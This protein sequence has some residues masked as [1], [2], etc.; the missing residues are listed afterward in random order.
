MCNICGKPV[1]Y[2]CGCSTEPVYCADDVCLQKMDAK[3]VFY[4]YNHPEKASL[5]NCLGINSNIN[6]EV[7]LEAIDDKLCSL[8]SVGFNLLAIDTN[9][10]NTTIINS[11]S[12][13]YVKSDLILD[14]SST[15]PVS[16]TSAGLKVDCCNCTGVT[17][18]VAF[19]AG[20]VIKS[21]N[22]YTT[23]SASY[24]TSSDYIVGVEI[25]DLSTVSGDTINYIKYTNTL[26]GD[27]KIITSI[28]TTFN[29]IINTCGKNIENESKT[30]VAELS[31]SRN[32]YS[33]TICPLITSRVGY[34]ERINFPYRANFQMDDMPIISDPEAS[35][36]TDKGILFFADTKYYSPSTSNGGVIRMINLNDKKCISLSGSMT[37]GISATTV[38]NT[39]GDIVQYDYPSS[40]CIDKTEITNGYP[41]LYFTAFN[42]CICRM[43]R[44]RTTEC[45]ERAN[46]KT[47]I[48]AGQSGVVGDVVGAG[49]SALFR[50]LYGIKKWYSLNGKPAFLVADSVNSKIKFVYYNGGG[51]NSASNWRVAYFGINTLGGLS[52]NINVEDSPVYPGTKR[53]FN[54]G[55]GSITI[56]DFNFTNPT[57]TDLTTLAN[58]VSHTVISAAAVG[59]GDGLGTVARVYNPS[60]ISKMI[61]S[62]TT[63]YLFS[64]EDSSA[65]PLT[66]SLRAFVESGY[67][68]PA[69]YTFTT[70]IAINT[71]P[72]GSIG[73]FGSTARGSSFGFFKDLQG[74]Y[75]DI[76]TGGIRLF[77]FASNT[78]SSIICGASSSLST[79]TVYPGDSMDTQYELAINC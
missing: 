12:D 42:N 23:L 66:T 31:T 35:S 49:S 29:S 24:F 36:T 60:S 57:L 28:G 15:A 38:N 2:K 52:D 39:W 20:P 13:Y 50:G 4:H 73:P 58:Y 56:R 63:Y 62:G 11:G 46:W 54:F 70:L 27:V 51:V 74:D 32:C 48:I 33:Y 3:C 71:N 5:L 44:E 69:N 30:I 40:I 22:F 43:V 17:K 72:Y 68:G 9:S 67:A 25:N 7:I 79:G 47:Y 10:I 61:K 6:L 77:N 19:Q 14:P 76:T 65:T 26:S 1:N 37:S 78:I 34:S 64:Q 18:Q 45:D 8:D 41:A 21:S 55:G 75:Y 59:T 53:L 16:I